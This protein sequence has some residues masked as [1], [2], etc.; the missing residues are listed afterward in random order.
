MGLTKK[1]M[2]LFDPERH[3]RLEEEAKQRHCSKGAL[4]REAVEKQILA[5]GETSRNTRLAA[6]KRL[7]S[8][9]EEI[10]D[11][12]EMEKLIARGHVHEG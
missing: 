1:V 5:K 11:W 12:D 9:K 8:M 6:A 4:I 3:D 2:V 10:T 7:I